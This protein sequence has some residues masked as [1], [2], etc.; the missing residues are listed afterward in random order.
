MLAEATQ[1]N[2]RLQSQVR[3]KLERLQEFLD[4]LET[5]RSRYTDLEHELLSESP[6]S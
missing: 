4:E 1:I 5:K 2:E 6:Q 3:R